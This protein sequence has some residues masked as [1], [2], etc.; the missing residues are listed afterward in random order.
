MGS[1]NPRVISRHPAEGE[2]L[3]N[4]SSSDFIDVPVSDG[5]ERVTTESK[6]VKTKTSRKKLSP[7]KKPQAADIQPK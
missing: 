6:K 4:G 3:G 7:T 2:N 1:A 5:T